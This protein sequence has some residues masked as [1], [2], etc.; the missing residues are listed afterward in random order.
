[1]PVYAGDT[2]DKWGYCDAVLLAELGLNVDLYF[3][4]KNWLLLMESVT[5]H[6]QV[7]GKRHAEPA[8]P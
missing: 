3:T 5:A 7:D 1:M 8:K 4:E 6:G 2:G